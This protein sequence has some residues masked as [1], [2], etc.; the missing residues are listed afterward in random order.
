M[1]SQ[2]FESAMIGGMFLLGTGLLELIDAS[3]PNGVAVGLLCVG[4][5]IGAFIARIPTANAG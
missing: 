2:K 1:L 4:A 5:S 3:V